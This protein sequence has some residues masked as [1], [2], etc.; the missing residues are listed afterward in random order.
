[1][2]GSGTTVARRGLNVYIVAC[3]TGVVPVAALAWYADA[4]FD[5]R[6]VLVLGGLIFLAEQFP[7]RLPSG[8][9][10]SLSFVLTIAAV[11]VAGPVEAVLVT[12]LGSVNVV[13]ARNRPLKRNIFNVAQL[14]LSSGL[15]AL[16]YAATGGGTLARG[17]SH[18][19][20]ALPLVVATAV[21][22]P[23]NTLLVSGAIA[24][25][26]SRATLAVWRAQFASLWASYLCFA[27]LG[28]LLALL[29]VE[30]G[31]AS[32]LLLLAPLLFARHAFAAATAM[33]DAFDSTVRTLVSTLEVKDRYTGGH[34]DRVSRLSEMTARAYGLP[35]RV[36]GAARY[37]GLMHDIGKL[38]VTGHLLRKAGRLTDHEAHHL[39]EHADAGARIIA[40][41]DVL[42]PALPGVRHHHE[43]LDG[44][45]YP[46]GLAGDDIPLVARIVSVADAFDA[47]TSTRSYRPARGLAEAFEELRRCAGT[48]FDPVCVAALE[49]A[50]AAEGWQPSPEDRTIRLDPLRLDALLSGP[51][52][53][54]IVVPTHEGRHE[55]A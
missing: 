2:V 53:S 39:R 7:V 12:V 37:A 44:S 49:A 20:A 19:V 47:L 45:G 17:G 29:Y 32:G 28:F 23:T 36:C 35:P 42:G 31:P 21:D 55:H 40:G 27:A 9:T 24:R 51:L 41:I 34:A 6:A 4:G 48:Q 22:F 50:V 11:L 1:M 15:A 13:V 52:K 26:D 16:A 3:V 8:S 54:D 10:Y 30:V 14:A 33:H 5:L 25:S 18:W 38:A 46:D 43:H